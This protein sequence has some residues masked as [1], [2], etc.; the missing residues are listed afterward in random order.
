MLG[1]R[2]VAFV[3]FAD[4]PPRLA[5][6]DRPRLVRAR[7]RMRVSELVAFGIVVATRSLGDF[8]A[9]VFVVDLVL[10]TRL[11]VL[12][13]LAQRLLPHAARRVETSGRVLVVGAGRAGRELVRELPRRRTRASSASSTT[14][15][16]S[17]AG[18]SS[19]S[20]CSAPLDDVERGGLAR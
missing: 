15:R 19:G 2:Y 8:P 14:T 18:G 12:A 17:L 13:R 1:T 4:L 9:R 11:V 20:R 16:A 6:R 3:A 5:L 10:C 7:R